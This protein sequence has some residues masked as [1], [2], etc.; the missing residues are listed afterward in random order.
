MKKKE[1]RSAKLMTSSPK[2]NEFMII[3]AKYNKVPC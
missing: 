1:F 3:L 2:N